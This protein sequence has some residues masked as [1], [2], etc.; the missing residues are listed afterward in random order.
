MFTHQQR[1]MAI[2][3]ELKSAVAAQTTTQNPQKKILY[4]IDHYIEMID[5]R[6]M[7][8][9]VMFMPLNPNVFKALGA[10]IVSGVGLIIGRTLAS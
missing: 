10:Y 1:H 4:L 2:L 7:Q 5:K 3:A 8:A 6:D 9:K